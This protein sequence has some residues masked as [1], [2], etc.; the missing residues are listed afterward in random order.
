MQEIR[1]LSSIEGHGKINMSEARIVL[2]QQM[3][4]EMHSHAA[5][6]YPE[7]CCGLMFGRLSFENGSDKNGGAIKKVLRLRRMKNAFDPKERYHRYTIDPKEF[8]EAEK[9]ADDKGDEI[10]GIYHSHPNAQ[11]RPSAFDRDHAWP[12]LSYV[13]IEVRESKALETRSWVLKDDRSEFL[14]EEIEISVK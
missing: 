8:L 13:V 11:A 6:T 2:D 1:N 3:F 4:A 9:D 14:P 5:S 10:V 12:T 7:E